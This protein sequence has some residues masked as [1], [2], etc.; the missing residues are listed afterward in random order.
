[1]SS[2]FKLFSNLKF[3]IML[4]LL[5]KLSKIINKIIL[6]NKDFTFFIVFSS[7]DAILEIYEKIIINPPI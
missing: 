3:S 4:I 7:L 2:K 5:I 1:M 6:I